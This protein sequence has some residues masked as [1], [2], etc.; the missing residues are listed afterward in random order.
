MIATFI[1]AALTAT[2]ATLPAVV[3]SAQA[4]DT[5]TLS[6]ANYGLATIVNRFFAK[7]LVIRAGNARLQLVLQ[8]M[9][10]VELQGGVIRDNRSG[11]DG[12]RD[13]PAPRQPS[14]DQRHDH[15]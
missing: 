8:D 13:H 14:D 5:I 9:S 6:R 15:I 7:P 4:D 12:L 2:P 1:L 10:G 11:R 3:A